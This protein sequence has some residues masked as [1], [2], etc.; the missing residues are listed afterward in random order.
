[1]MPAEEPRSADLALI[2]SFLD[3]LWME[4]GLSENTLSA[5]RSDLNAVSSWL[6]AAG[7]DLRAVQR[8]DL[9]RYLA[10]RV[11]KGA[12]PRTTARLLSSLRRFYRHQLRQGS[13]AADP[14]ALIDAPKVGRP[15]P[16]VLTEEQ[17]EGLL[18]APDVDLPLGLRDRTMLELLY[19]CGLRVSELVGLRV[20][21]IDLNQGVLR[22]MGKGSRE[23]LVPVGDEAV[24]WTQ[25]YLREGRTPLLDGRGPSDFL[26]VTRR[27][28]PMTRQAFWQLVRRYAAKVG[29][30]RH[31]SPHTLRHA[32]ATHLLNHGADLRVVQMMLGHSDLSTTQIYTHVAQ[33][34]LQ[35]LHARHHPRG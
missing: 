3:A 31:L 23:R 13:V 10:A 16:R 35:A 30:D 19:A 15:L 9:L 4:R 27:G 12:R 8:E 26:F 14:T 18:T 25:R 5:Y 11:N 20:D 28:G 7:L 32:F 24:A 33:L 6:G 22:I 1:M 2:E 29:Y 34:R 21:Q 17:V